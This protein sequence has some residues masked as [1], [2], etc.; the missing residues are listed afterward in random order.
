MSGSVATT[1]PFWRPDVFA[2]RR[3]FLEARA[4]I[5]AAVRATLSGRGLVEVETPALQVSP[6]AEPHLMAFAT[7]LSGPRPGQAATRY[8]HTSPELAMKKLLVAG[9]PRIFQLARVFRNGEAAHTHHPEFTMLEWYRAGAGYLDLIDDVSAL[10][11]AAASVAD[12][13]LSWQGS[14]CDP[15][16][17]WERLTVAEA[18]DRHAG[19]D[20]V[21]TLTPDGRGDLAALDARV[22]HLGHGARPGDAYEDLFFRVM[23]DRV[24]PR[25]GFGAPTV[26]T[27]Y[28]AEMAALSR[29]KPDDRRLAERWELYVCGLELA[30]A[31]GELTDPAEQR[32]RFAAAETLRGRLYDRSYPV[33]EDFLA[34]LEHGMPP[35]AGIALGVDRLVMLAVGAS[36][37]EDVLWVPV[38][39]R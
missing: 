12:D 36:R 14:T 21:A 8:L 19:V 4:R 33:D 9:M 10:L 23:L 39:D 15:A 5:L 18:F 27:D 30:N 29:R 34:A 3:P 32:E 22:G 25:L 20:L 26:L 11:T 24:E 7:E 28:P 13:R 17:P 37:I 31:F 38:A 6:G 35:A 1:V 2:R 16:G